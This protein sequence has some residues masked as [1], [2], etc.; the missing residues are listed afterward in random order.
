MRRRL[1]LTLAPL[2]VLGLAVAVLAAAREGDGPREAPPPART[3]PPPPATTPAPPPPPRYQRIRW[4]RSRAV[5]SASAGRLVNGVRLPREGRDFFTWDPVKKRV[6]NRAWRR[7]GHDRLVRTVLRV[8]REHRRANAGAPRVGV[9]DLSRPR[10]GNFGPQWGSVGHATHQ[11]GMDVDVYYPRRDHREFHPGP[12]RNVDVDLAQDL[13][14][15][16]VR[17]GAEKVFVGP[18]L[19]LTGPPGVV[20]KLYR[21]DDH[22]HVRLR[23]RPGGR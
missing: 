12:P 7:W 20:Q 14:N 17:A 8:L 10:G 5:G 11:D 22:V 23:P 2:L 16:F 1:L 15:R 9:G 13:V 18:S 19:T 6:G 4:R 21:H 3:A